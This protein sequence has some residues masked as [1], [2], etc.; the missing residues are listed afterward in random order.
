MEAGERAAPALER[1]RTWLVR[2]NA[3]ITGVVDVVIGLNLL[4]DG[5]AGFS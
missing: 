4:G 2:H 5:I 3:V 1:F